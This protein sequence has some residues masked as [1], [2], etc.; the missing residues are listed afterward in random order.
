MFCSWRGTF[1]KFA[2]SKFS[3]ILEVHNENYY[4]LNSYTIRHHRACDGGLPADRRVCLAAVAAKPACADRL[5]SDSAS[6]GHADHRGHDAERAHAD[7]HPADCDSGHEYAS[8]HQHGS[9]YSDGCF[10]LRLGYVR[11]GCQRPGW[12]LV[13]CW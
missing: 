2:S 12:D 4:Q 1:L 9:S 3:T 13:L 5:R 8:A 10:V 7:A 6:H 11:Q